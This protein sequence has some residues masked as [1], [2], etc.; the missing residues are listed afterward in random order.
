M[1]NSALS[2]V[3]LVGAVIQGCGTEVGNPKKPKDDQ[4]LAYL[5][6]DPSVAGDLIS[7]QAD[8]VLQSAA[9]DLRSI[10]KLRLLPGRQSGDSQQPLLNDPLKVTSACSLGVDGGV[11]VAISI[12]G[13]DKRSESDGVFES[14]FSVSRDESTTVNWR[15]PN[16]VLGCT[17]D[18]SA[19]KLDWTAA[20]GLALDAQIQQKRSTEMTRQGPRGV[21]SRNVQFELTGE[22]HATFAQDSANAPADGLLIK[23]TVT[24]KVDKTITTTRH[25]APDTVTLTTHIE[26]SADAPVIVAIE[27]DKD[28]VAWRTKTVESGTVVS[29]QVEGSR[30][31]ATYSN[32]KFSADAGCAPVSGAVSGAIFGSDGASL[33]SFK[34]GFDQGGGVITYA[35]GTST[36]YVADYCGLDDAPKL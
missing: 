19:I 15:Q 12:I 17:D 23:K 27:R 9:E 6:V 28:G 11:S 20:D 18:A 7:S 16:K 29:T 30:L 24:S 1:K 8:D 5:V 2:I 14:A 13:E 32:L 34:I 33:L 25:N 35:D 21:F 26:V 22:R 10:A 3:F 36:P 31:E 4:K